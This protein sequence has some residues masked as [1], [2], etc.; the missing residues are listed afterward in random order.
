MEKSLPSNAFTPH[1]SQGKG[2]RG[3]MGSTWFGL[4]AERGRESLGQS[5]WWVFRGKGKTGRAG[6]TD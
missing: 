5:F 6:E 4:E 2:M 1:I 3:P